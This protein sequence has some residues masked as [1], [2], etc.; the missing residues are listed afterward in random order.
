MEMKE[1][2]TTK[3]TYSPPPHVFSDMRFWLIV[4]MLAAF[5][6]ILMFLGTGPR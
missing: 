4:V 1:H 6:G 3:K 5:I 2:S